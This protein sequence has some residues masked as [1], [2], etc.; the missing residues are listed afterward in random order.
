[1]PR[2]EYGKYSHLLAAPLDKASFDPDVIAI[3]CDGAQLMRLIQGALRGKGGAITSS[4][5]GAFGCSRIIAWTINSNECNYHIPGGGERMS[6]LT[7]DHEVVFAAA[8][9][10]VEQLIKELKEGAEA[11]YTD[12]PIRGPLPRGEPT[13]PPEYAALWE[14]LHKTS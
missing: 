7:Q 14:H 8:M 11:H 9:S 12:Y 13:L 3:Y 2:L 4:C 6:A 5:M 10:Q 1:M